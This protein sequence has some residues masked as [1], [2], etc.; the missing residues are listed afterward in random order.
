[1]SLILLITLPFAASLLAALLPA[2]ARN[3]ESTLAGVVALLCVGL[4]ALW[5]RVALD[6]DACCDDRG[7]GMW[8]R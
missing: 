7:G 4:A 6:A 2:N 1:M 8:R 5:R 3:A